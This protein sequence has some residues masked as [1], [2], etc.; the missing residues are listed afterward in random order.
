[1]NE[2]YY[3]ALRGKSNI[4]DKLEIGKNYSITA[5]CSITQSKVDDNHDGTVNVT[6]KAEPMTIEITKNNGEIIRAKD[7]RRNSQKIRNY[8]FKLYADEGVVEDFSAVYDA[9]TLEI[10]SLMPQILRGAVKRLEL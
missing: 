10:L 1:M 2:T 4:P 6:F 8:L 9:A 5:D 3:I 7:P